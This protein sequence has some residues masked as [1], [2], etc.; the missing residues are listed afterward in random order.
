MHRSAVKQF[1]SKTNHKLQKSSD[2]LT[3]KV[4]IGEVLRFLWERR[5]KVSVLE[6]FL[7]RVEVMGNKIPNPMLLFIY[8]CI[9]VIAISAVCS[10]FHVSAVNPVT[11]E[12]VEVVNLFSKDGFVRMLT[13]FVTNFTGTS[14]LGLTLTCMLGVG[15]AEASGLFHVALRGLAKAKGSDLK[16]IAIFCFVCVM[17]DCTGGAGFVV[18]PPLGALIWAAMG[19]NPMAGMLAAYA[20]VSGAFASNLMITSMDVVNMGYTEAA[21]KLLIPDISLSPSM[22]WYFSAVSVV[23]LTFFSTL[24]TVKVVEPRM[25]RYTGDYVEQADDPTPLDNKGLKAALI[26]FLAYIALIV[27][28]C[29]TGVLADET[30]SLLNS[31]APLMSGMTVLIALMFAI[32]GIAFGYASGRFKNVDD[33]AAAMTSAMASASSQS[34]ESTTLKYSASAAASPAFYGRSMPT[35]FLV[36][37]LDDV[38]ISALPFVGFPR[39]FVFGG[40]VV[41]D[42]HFDV[43]PACKARFDAFV[44]VSGGIVAWYGKRNGLHGSSLLP[45]IALLSHSWSASCKARATTASM[46]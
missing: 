18:M 5:K 39:G 22:N 23:F 13:T 6:R 1:A 46:S 41:H 29:V 4:K 44:H 9:A 40:P 35:V 36:H 19:R 30:G 43:F 15:V 10:I 8:L 14:A 28:L 21:A 7:H 24:I 25:G 33:V 31:K 16:V 11:G 3:K 17:A 27:V 38:G 45:Y 2:I 26:A 20:S 37:D 34:S 32:P 12:L 42:D